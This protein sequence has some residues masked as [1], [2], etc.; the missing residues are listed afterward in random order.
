[1]Y[2]RMFGSARDIPSGQKELDSWALCIDL[3]LYGQSSRKP[4]KVMVDVEVAR[5][6]R[7]W[8]P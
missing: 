1:M 8:R 7:I 3:Q 6:V 4:W 5:K 2:D